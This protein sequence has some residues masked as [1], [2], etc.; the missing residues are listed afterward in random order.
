MPRAWV[1]LLG[2]AV[3]QLTNNNLLAMGLVCH[4][5]ASFEIPAVDKLKETSMEVVLLS[6]SE[7]VLGLDFLPFFFQR[8]LTDN[9]PHG[10]ANLD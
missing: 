4:D 7:A 6:V 2:E 9:A 5:S 8:A 10:F 3:V 1:S